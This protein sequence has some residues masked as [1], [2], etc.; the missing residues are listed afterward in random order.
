MRRMEELAE[1]DLDSEFL[2]QANTFCHYIYDNADPKTVSGGRTITGTGVYFHR[3]PCRKNVAADLSS[4][5][6]SLKQI[7]NLK[8]LMKSKRK[9]K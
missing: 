5:Y 2:D 6:S 8:R 9:N 7:N 4:T 1:E 3:N